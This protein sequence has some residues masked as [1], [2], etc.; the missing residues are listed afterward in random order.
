MF[1]RATNFLMNVFCDTKIQHGF[2]EHEQSVVAELLFI[3]GLE[4][5][6]KLCIRKSYFILSILI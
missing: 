2:I 4:I 6:F 5:Y 1:P 3:V